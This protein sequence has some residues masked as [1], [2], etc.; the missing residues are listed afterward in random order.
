[1]MNSHT[2]LKSSRYAVSVILALSALFAVVISTIN[3]PGNDATAQ[4]ADE[5][6][7]A[8][9]KRGAAWWAALGP[10]ERVNAV[11]GKD[12]DPDVDGHQDFGGGTI[13]EAALIAVQAD[14]SPTHTAKSGIDALVDGSASDTN[15]DIYAV[16]DQ[17]ADVQALR[18]FQ[19]VEL[20][21]M[22]V[23]CAEA[24][25]A[26]GEDDGDLETHDQ[27]LTADG[28]QAEGSAVCD[29]T[30][31]AAG[32]E[33]ESTAPK[34]YSEVK[35]LVDGVGQAILGLDDPGS[36]SS[37]DN[38][39]AEQWWNSLN[40]CEK[41]NALWGNGLGSCTPGTPSQVTD[42]EN[43]SLQNLAERPY[44]SMGEMT[45]LDADTKALVNDRWEWIYNEAG[46]ANEDD[47]DAVV[48]WW[49]SLNCAA[50][51]TAVG[52]DNEPVSP[53]PDAED[54]C[55]SWDGL[56]NTDPLTA[57]GK[58][59]HAKVFKHGRA[60]LVHD[61]DDN[62]VPNVA[63]WW[64][65][66]GALPDIMID[67]VV[68]DRRVLAVYGNPPMRDPYDHDND[69]ATDDVTTVTA[70][71][72]AVF[73]KD[74]DEL[75]GGITVNA[76]NTALS[77]HLLA[78]ITTL[79]ERN[80]FDVDTATGVD[81]DD[82]TNDDSWHYSAKGIVDALANEVFDPPAQIPD[83][84]GGEGEDGSGNDETIADDMEFDWP[85]TPAGENGNK[86][87]TVGDWS[88]D[89]DCRVKR[90]AVGEDNDYLNAEVANAAP[91]GEP[92]NG[93]DAEGSI[94]CGHYPGS[95]ATPVI[96]PTAQMRVDT[97]GIALLG[98]SERGRPSFNDEAT[99][100]P[101]VTGTGQVGSE[102]TAHVGGINDEEGDPNDVGSTLEFSYQWYSGEDKVGTDSPKYILQP[103]DVTKRISIEVS[104][105]DG[106]RQHEAV[107]S[108]G[109]STIAGSPG[110]ISRI[111]PAIRG[112]TVSAGNKVVLRVLPYGL[113]DVQSDS[114]S[115]GDGVTWTQDEGDPDETSVDDDDTATQWEIEYTA[116]SRPGEF[117]VTASLTGGD[118]Q[119][120]DEDDRDAVCSATINV[121]V[122]R[123]TADPA[124][125]EPPTNPPGEIPTIL[126][127][128]DGNQYEVF[129]PE[130]GGTFTGEGYSLSATA[131]VIP[132]G[133]YIGIRVSDEGS[134]S[135]AGMSHQRYT[136]GGNMFKVSA[137][138][139]SSAAIS[140]YELRSAA[141]V[142]IPLPDELKTNISD[143]AI[144]AINSDDS[145]TILSASVRLGSGGTHVCGNLSAIP[146]SVAVGSE[147]AP[148]PLPTPT[149]EPEPEIPETGGNAPS[150]IGVLWLL[151]LGIGIL[152]LG[153]PA[154]LR[155]RRNTL[156]NK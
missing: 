34:P 145:L 141:T 56:N 114:L 83:P 66:V 12:N 52:D 93:V 33:V 136:L 121:Q 126:T 130:V 84:F 107:R 120:K 26:V 28:F 14:Y 109:T 92:S 82:D 79:L 19:S 80:G 2:S 102:L 75:T 73:A 23:T 98:L 25:I 115:A 125:E 37:A 5:S 30:L 146:A 38:A 128:G 22:Y 63:A 21:W 142:C 61:V 45:G 152:L 6:I 118:C 18:G 113:Q 99:G 49:D 156:T 76:A 57:D 133:E 35:D 138:D 105:Y 117:D 81:T 112:V 89:T 122:R 24:R 95:G 151:T 17:I 42:A 60:I 139:A 46:G 124:A 36:K 155:R 87:A 100:N 53:V 71:D 54:F 134:A 15:D 48:H 143:L 10:G 29:A 103:R 131:G 65:A 140:S 50:M 47:K 132:N 123:P 8:I 40:N 4:V 153:I 44:N 88:E 101:T 62:P 119:P 90:L 67:D 16:G 144:V 129:T 70:D 31:N 7:N 104:F 111:E 13:V 72:T 91:E 116:P 137:V 150:S 3:L 147:G 58:A 127:D 97:V 78:R 11:L 110:E 85:Y 149:P 27:D 9:E 94:Y 64:D 135:N 77:T 41:I 106:A 59:R 74:Y 108:A 51:R 154:A 86:A 1:M 55:A 69:G 43:P 148:A 32:D 68:Y 39:R 20:W 96:N